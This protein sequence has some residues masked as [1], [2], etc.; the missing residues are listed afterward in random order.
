[1]DADYG[2]CAVG[3]ARVKDRTHTVNSDA[4]CEEMVER[5]RCLYRDN[6]YVEFSWS[7]GR[8]RTLKQNAA[9]N[10]WLG[11]LAQRLNDAGLDMRRVLKPSVSIP[12]TA[13][14]AKEYLWRP[15]QMALTGKQST[16]EAE[17]A[18]YS[19]V[20]DV[21]AR[22]L[23][24]KFGVEAPPWPKKPEQHRKRAAA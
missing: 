18:D 20:Q 15:V 6:R 24:E 23:G 16:A 14:A 2:A 7:T 4:S 22:H 13:S 9:L 21:L 5:V 11:W 19:A 17:R 3:R 1:M 10:L 12:W 8:Q